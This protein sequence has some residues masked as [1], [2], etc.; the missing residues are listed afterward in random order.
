MEWLPIESAPK[1]A[2][3]LL[4]YTPHP[5]LAGERRVYEGLWHEAQGTWTSVNGFLIHRDATHW[6]PLPAPPGEKL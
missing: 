2:V 5:R 4:G 6:Q 3:V 1:D